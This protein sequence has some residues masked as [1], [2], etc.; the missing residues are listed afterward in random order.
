[1]P[2]IARAGTPTTG[3]IGIRRAALLAPLAKS[4][5]CYHAAADEQ[6]CCNV[7]VAGQNRQYSQRAG[8]I[9]SAG[10]R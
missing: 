2:Y 10:K 8:R 7:T 4:F 5:I 9:I 6:Q 3:L 1:M